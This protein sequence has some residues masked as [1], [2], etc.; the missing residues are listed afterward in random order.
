MVEAPEA[1]PLLPTMAFEMDVAGGSDN[2][3]PSGRGSSRGEEGAAQGESS[4][5]ERRERPRVTTAPQMG[6]IDQNGDPDWPA[7]YQWL[8]RLKPDPPPGPPPRSGDSAEDRRRH[9]LDTAY[10]GQRR[11]QLDQMLRETGND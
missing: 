7:V 5:G 9:I 3:S 10:D 8:G 11:A 1:R 4:R 6:P 2:E